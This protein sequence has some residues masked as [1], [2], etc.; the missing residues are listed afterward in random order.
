MSPLLGRLSHR[1]LR[2][3]AFALEH[4]DLGHA[5][6]IADEAHFFAGQSRKASQVHTTF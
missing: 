3:V 4:V 5:I 2:V 6:G 1:P